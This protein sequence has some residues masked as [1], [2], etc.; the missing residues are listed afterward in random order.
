M[1][2][3][4]NICY[5]CGQKLK[6]NI[7]DDHVPPKQFYAKNI[8][9]IHNLNLFTLPTHISC[10][11]SYQKDE[12]YFV[13]SLAPLTI[14][15]YSGNAIWVD[16]S[17]RLKRP[18][19]KKIGQMILNEFDQRIILPDDKI[20]KRFDGKRTRRI[21]WKITRG[22]FFKET[23]RFIPEDTPRLF[24]FISV[25]EEPPQEFFYI[26]STPSRGQYPGVFD[27]KY[28]DF[29]E[30]DNFHFWAMLFWDS[31]IILIAFHDP[32]CSCDKCK[33]LR[34]KSV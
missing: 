23:G 28:I 16:I 5:L 25:N 24:K 2:N 15:S 12:D 4:I 33:I 1:K 20:I 6:E 26:S 27:Y 10:N 9:K 31:L 32:S 29:P 11:M 7:D 22:L 18:Q 8:R 19:S 30:L 13:Y 3:R 34:D 14:G 21:I 17:K